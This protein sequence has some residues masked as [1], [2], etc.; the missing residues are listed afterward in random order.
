MLSIGE[1]Y[2]NIVVSAASSKPSLA[3]WFEV[4]GVDG[5]VVVMPAYEER[6]SLHDGCRGCL[7]ARCGSDKRAE[8]R[9]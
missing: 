4:C 3:V 2:A 7:A 9:C 1:T 8:V 5:G 6:C